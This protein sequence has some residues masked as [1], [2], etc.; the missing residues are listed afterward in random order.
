M[1]NEEFRVGRF[2]ATSKAVLHPATEAESALEKLCASWLIFLFFLIFFLP[3]QVP[4]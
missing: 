1:G 4:F 2:G 3:F